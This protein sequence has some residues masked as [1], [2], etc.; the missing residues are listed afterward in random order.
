MDERKEKGRL[1]DAKTY[2][3]FNVHSYQG[4]A[5]KGRL[6]IDELTHQ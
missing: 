5:L 2:A 6:F 3:E 1:Q 4:F